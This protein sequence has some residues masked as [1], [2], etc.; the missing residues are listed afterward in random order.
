MKEHP[1]PEEDRGA[2]YMK[3]RCCYLLEHIEEVTATI[4]LAIMCLFVFMQLISR[5]V[6]KDPLLFTEE[7]ARFSYVW[8]TFIGLSLAAKTREHISINV[9]VQ[10]LP[11]KTRK[12]INIVAH[13]VSFVILSY[14]F[15]WG[16]VFAN[17][18]KMM[19]SPA[20]EFSLLIVYIS[21]PIGTAMAAIRT[22]QMLVEEVRQLKL[23]S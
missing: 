19:I 9:F 16:V 21:F 17:F 5:Y 13:F 23:E 20:L 1:S 3:R 15:Y 14:L 7:V 2:D 12:R 11:S 18:N 4:F 22:L 6:L 10:R 8:V